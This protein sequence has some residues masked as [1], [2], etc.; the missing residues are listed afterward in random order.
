LTLPTDGSTTFDVDPDSW[1]RLPLGCGLGDTL[2]EWKVVC[3]QVC[4]DGVEH[5]GDVCVSGNHS[6]LTNWGTGIVTYLT[7]TD[8]Y[9]FCLRFP[10]GTPVPGEVEYKFRK[11][12]CTTW[13]TI[14]NRVIV[15]DNESLPAVKVTHIWDD[16][17]GVCDEAVGVAETTFDE[18]SWGRLKGTY[19]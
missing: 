19:R 5:S 2:I 12:D 14:P 13:E 4:L 16:G 17:P 6:L 18:V 8:L 7:A 3:F 10:A 9:E 1:N 15:V 11:D